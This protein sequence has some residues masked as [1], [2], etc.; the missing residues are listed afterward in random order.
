MSGYLGARRKGELP[1][2]NGAEQKISTWVDEH[3][4]ALLEELK[5]F[6]RI[7]SLTGYEGEAQKY[8][9]VQYEKLGLEVE[10][11]E[12]DVRE[13]F[14]K[15]PDI[16]QYPT[17]WEPELDLVIRYPDIC[18]YEQ[19]LNSG[20][21]DQ[22][23]YKGRPNVVGTWKGTGGG[24]SLILNGHVD[25]VTVGDYSRWEHDPFGAEQVGERIYARSSSD[26]KG[27]L[28]ACA[29]ALEVLQAAGIQLRGDVICQSVVNEEH[30]G[31]GSLA[32]VARGYRADAAI[33]ADGGS[34]IKTETGGGVYWEIKVVG[35]EVHTGGR[36][37]GGE[38]YGVSAIEKAALVVRALCE[39]EREANR[40]ATRLSLGIG[41]I[42]GGTY[43]TNTAGECTIS[44][45]AYYSAAMGVGVP[46]IKAVKDLLRTA[47]DEVAGTD[48]WLAEHRPE[49]SFLHYDDAYVYPEDHELLGVMC[50]A[51]EDMLGRKMRVGSMS[52][53]D[54][55]HLGNRGGTPCLVCG[56][57][58]GPAHAANEY[59][60]TEDYL[61]Y[62][63]F[64]ALTVYRWCG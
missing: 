63:K 27:G 17:S 45:V 20:Y 13:L 41:M 31:N 28:L 29:K 23:N 22:L 34:G 14:E 49:L 15:Y 44:G 54:A 55:R 8:M 62:I 40:D 33:C 26:M 60:N 7:P 4:D 61:D 37:R 10:V 2:K 51:G 38:M 35:R 21:A 47:I 64:L 57:G 11:F 18:T 16:A 3:R 5:E 36:W 58:N 25:A 32:C 50:C 43:A 59:I 6:L 24:R 53:C 46:G 52:A 1:V 48:S 9:Q 56:P 19:W 39:Q 12:P 42:N 30:A